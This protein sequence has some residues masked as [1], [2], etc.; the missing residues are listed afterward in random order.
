MMR[1]RREKTCTCLVHETCN[2]IELADWVWSGRVC[3]KNGEQLMAPICWPL[4]GAG[5]GNQAD[6]VGCC[7]AD[8]AMREATIGLAN[9]PNFVAC[10]GLLWATKMGLDLG[11]LIGLYGP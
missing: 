9:K 3:T 1:L 7:K 4:A 6:G 8:W 11:P 2:V 5:H 10:L